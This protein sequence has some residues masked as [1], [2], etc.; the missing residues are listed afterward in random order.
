MQSFRKK[1]EWFQM[2]T[3]EPQNDGFQDEDGPQT[4]RPLTDR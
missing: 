4:E 1:N 3:D 2:K